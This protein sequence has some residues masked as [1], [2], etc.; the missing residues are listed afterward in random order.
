[1]AEVDSAGWPAAPRRGRCGRAVARR[2]SRSVVV[3]LRRADGS[4]DVEVAPR[5]R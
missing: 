4:T 3:V 5:K 2:T 1:V